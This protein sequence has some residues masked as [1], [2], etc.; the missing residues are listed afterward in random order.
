MHFLARF[1]SSVTHY[2][3]PLQ[4]S[5][6]NREYPMLSLYRDGLANLDGL[7]TE[8]LRQA[9]TVE[10]VALPPVQAGRAQKS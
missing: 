5:V 8:L 4:A 10:L 6:S 2:P 9:K 7:A 1:P 3:A